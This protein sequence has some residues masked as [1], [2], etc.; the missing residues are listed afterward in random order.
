MIPRG[1]N[2][3]DGD[4][5]VEGMTRE[6]VYERF[7]R[8][9]VQLAR[10]VADRAGQSGDVPAEDLVGYGALGLLEAFDRFEPSLD[11][12]FSSYASYRILGQM[13]DAERR[14][15][16]VT[17]RQRQVSRELAVATAKSREVLGREPGHAEMAAHL[18]VDMDTYW[19]LRALALPATRESSSALNAD[20]RLGVE[21][22]VGPRRM[23]EADAR[24]AL[25]TSIL[26]LLPKERQVVLLYYS[27]DCSLAEIGAV[28]DVTPSRVS[29]IMASARVKLRKAIGIEVGVDYSADME[30]MLVEPPANSR[31]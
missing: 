15:S 18:G 3:C 7:S 17:R 27:R 29:Q 19:R 1:Y 11:V 28:L 8:R 12:D 23:M 2:R 10:R 24:A 31:A 9:I 6:D 20:P 5:L 26:A 30:G 25:R 21:E 13:L 14:A 4:R 22:A 16:G